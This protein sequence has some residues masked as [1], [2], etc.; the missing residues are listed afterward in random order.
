MMRLPREESALA[1][2][3]PEK[4][5]V[6]AL[7]SG[8]VVPAS[9]IWRPDHDDCGSITELWLRKD[10]MFPHCP[11]CGRAASFTLSEQIVHISED[12]DF[13]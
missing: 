3:N 10:G 4:R 9:G 1:Q 5:P 6:E 2:A 11:C 7:F 13:Q 12:P 8:T